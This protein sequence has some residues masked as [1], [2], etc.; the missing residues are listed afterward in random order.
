[1]FT[2][3]LL[4][5]IVLIIMYLLYQLYDFI[6]HHFTCRDCKV[7]IPNDPSHY[8]LCMHCKYAGNIVHHNCPECVYDSNGKLVHHKCPFC[9]IKTSNEESN[10]DKQ[11]NGGML[12]CD[13][14]KKIRNRK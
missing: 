13:K 5:V 1:M 11:R 8:M 4:I 3:I 7:H 14:C 9:G 2:N 12:Y 10:L 6:A